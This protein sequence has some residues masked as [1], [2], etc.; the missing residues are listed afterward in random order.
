MS[1]PG[2]N[3]KANIGFLYIVPLK[4]GLKPIHTIISVCCWLLFLYIVPLKQGLK[5]TETIS[6]IR[7]QCCFYT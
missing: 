2:A 1:R 3:A 6:G 7:S 4:Q 5:Q